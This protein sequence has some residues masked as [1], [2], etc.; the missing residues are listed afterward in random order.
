MN[1]FNSDL[2]E[3]TP[4]LMQIVR[5]AQSI[6]EYINAQSQLTSDPE[7]RERLREQDTILAAALIIA[8]GAARGRRAAITS[9]E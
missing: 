5:M 4:E 3:I 6:S 7:E 1:N 2:P 9:T 8:D